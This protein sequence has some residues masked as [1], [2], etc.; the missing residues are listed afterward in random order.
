MAAHEVVQMYGQQVSGFDLRLFI[1]PEA[2]TDGAL[3]VELGEHLMRSLVLPRAQLSGLW[4]K[5][6][7]LDARMNVGEFTEARW[8][9]AVPKLRAGTYH[10]LELIAEDPDRV[11][12]RIMLGAQVNPPEPQRG[13]PIPVVGTVTVRCSLS[14][15]REL[16]GS[17]ERVEALL[18]LG[19]LAWNGTEG[20]AYG[21]ANVTYSPRF[22]PFNPSG[23]QHPDY[24]P[25]WEQ[26][27]GTP[28]VR[29]HPIP[30]AFVGLNVDMNL[31]DAYCAGRGIKGA[32]WANFLTRDHVE[33]VGGERKLRES[34][35]GCRL[36]PLRDGGLLI[37]ATPSPVPDDTP[38]HRERFLAL[39]RHLQPVFI[40]R[41]GTPE[42]KQPLL[43]YF[44]RERQSIV[45]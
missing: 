36:E 6:A 31:E 13:Y 39:H 38:E 21:F 18:A 20:A 24:I 25:P 40:P 43:G 30:V 14:Y 17:P 7:Q 22:V 33:R 28:D 34:L 19:T 16:A 23:P 41:S 32:F 44:Y 2:V 3:L 10:V 35:P 37:V 9:A 1:R 12:H 4:T 42:R 27:R 8:S 45:P 29:P 15:I 26:P 5:R 11:D